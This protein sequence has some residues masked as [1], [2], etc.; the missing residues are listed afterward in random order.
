[1]KPLSVGN[2]TQASA[3]HDKAY[4][5]KFLGISRETLDKLRRDGKITYVKMGVLVRFRDEDLRDYIDSCVQQ[6]KA[7]GA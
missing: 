4:A 1:M 3:L 5:A 7:A 6:K 2:G